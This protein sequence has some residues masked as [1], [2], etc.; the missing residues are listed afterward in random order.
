MT[1]GPHLH[2]EVWKDAKVVD[3]LLYTDLSEIKS[4]DMLQTRHEE[5]WE[6]DHE[7]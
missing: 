4:A 1:T 6:H 7:H 3:P 2:R 5:K